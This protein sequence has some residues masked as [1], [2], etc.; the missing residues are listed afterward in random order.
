MNGV[1]IL[2]KLLCVPSSTGRVCSADVNSRI[3]FA[4]EIFE[5]LLRD[6]SDFKDFMC[7][8]KLHGI[9]LALVGSVCGLGFDCKIL[10]NFTRSVWGTH[11]HT[12]C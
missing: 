8:R 4:F 9:T 2:S 11:A 5:M 3:A 7:A 6:I 12:G 1:D 10:M